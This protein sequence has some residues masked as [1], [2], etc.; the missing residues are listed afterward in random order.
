MAA[1]VSN[2]MVGSA[3]LHS[4]LLAFGESTQDTRGDPRGASQHLELSNKCACLLKQ[5]LSQFYSI[6]HFPVLVSP[7]PWIQPQATFFQPVSPCLKE[8]A[9]L[10]CIATQDFP[11]IYFPLGIKMGNRD[12][13]TV[14]GTLHISPKNKMAR[15]GK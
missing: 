8:I 13:G 11:T 14:P 3:N 1:Y 9:S 5:P 4:A 6:F 12:P 10:W 7:P 2:S 15:P